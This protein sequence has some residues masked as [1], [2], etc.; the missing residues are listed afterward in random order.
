MD[1]Y[2]SIFIQWKPYGLFSE[3]EKQHHVRVSHRKTTSS[4]G[5]LTDSSLYQ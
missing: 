3:G 2:N 5:E 4:Q 1:G